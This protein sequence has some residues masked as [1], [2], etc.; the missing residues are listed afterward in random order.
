MLLRSTCMKEMQMHREN[1]HWIKEQMAQIPPA[2]RHQA[3]QGYE[4]VYWE[5]YESEPVEHKK[6]N[7]AVRAANIRLRKFVERIKNPT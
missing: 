4:Q 1:K 6:K 7:A 3:K 2:Y 5:A